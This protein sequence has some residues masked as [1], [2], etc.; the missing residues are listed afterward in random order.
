M[1]TANLLTKT[2]ASGG[3]VRA[4]LVTCGVRTRPW[5]LDRVESAR[6]NVG[7]LAPDV[8]AD[9]EHKLARLRKLAIVASEV[10]HGPM[11]LANSA[12]AHEL[13]ARCRTKPTVDG[14]G[15]VDGDHCKVAS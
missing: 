6:R 2:V 3:C 12:S 11:T 8:V 4:W 15:G 13:Q 9:S 14:S 10:C 1:L 5:A 7:Q